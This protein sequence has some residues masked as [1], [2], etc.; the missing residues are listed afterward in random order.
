MI[1]GMRGHSSGLHL[2]LRRITTSRRFLSLRAD[3]R[4]GTS[5]IRKIQIGNTNK[6]NSMSEAASVQPFSESEWILPSRA[7]VG[8]ISLI[9]AECAVFT[10]FV[11]AYLFYI[12][13]SLS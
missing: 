7:R 13:K 3:D 12:G 6:E 2:H 8:V 10:I 4:S 11:L 9:V 1:R 5:S